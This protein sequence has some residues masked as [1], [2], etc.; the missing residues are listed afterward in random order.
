MST[1]GMSVTAARTL[2]EELT[3]AG[4][5]VLVL[6]DFDKAG[7]SIIGTLTHDTRRYA[8]NCQPNVVDLGLRLGDVIAEDLPREKVT[9]VRQQHPAWNLRGNGATEEEIEVLVSHPYVAGYHWPHGERVELNAFTSDLF[10]AWLE[11]KLKRVGCRKV[12]PDTA[13]LTAAYCRAGYIAEVN[14]QLEVLHKKLWPRCQKAPVPKTLA[15]Q[16]RG[17]LKRD[18]TMSW[19]AAVAQIAEI[20]AKK[21]R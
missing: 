14:Q 16:V 19:D 6:R 20:R 7:F 15:R 11:R 4:V 5:R 21:G 3:H 10:I 2:V 8:F 17:R 1:K 12:I 9:Y 13:A 18:S